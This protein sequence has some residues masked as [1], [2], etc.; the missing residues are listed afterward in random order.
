MREAEGQQTSPSN[1]HS[2]VSRTCS[3]LGQLREDSAGSTSVPLP[4]PQVHPRVISNKDNMIRKQ[5]LHSQDRGP[6][7]IRIL[8]LET[9]RIRQLKQ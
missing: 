5:H 4:P 6:G 3:S 7:H 1:G 2:A 8:D 9:L